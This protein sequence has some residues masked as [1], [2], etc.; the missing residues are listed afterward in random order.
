MFLKFTGCTP[1]SVIGYVRV[2]CTYSFEPTADQKGIFEVSPRFSKEGTFRSLQY[3]NKLRGG[4]YFAS[5]SDILPILSN[6]FAN[7]HLGGD[8]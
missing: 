8:I 6:N 7:V 3:Y 4:V 2:F 1:N 5:P